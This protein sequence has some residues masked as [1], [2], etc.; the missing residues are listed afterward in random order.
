LH[1]FEERYK[2]MVGSALRDGS[3]FGIVLAKDEGIVNTG[4]TVRVEKVLQQYPDGRLDILTMGQRRFE[5]HR[6]N[7]ERDYLQGEVTYF[8]D[9]D[10]AT[11]PPELRELAVTNYHA[12][13]ELASARSHSEP[14]FADPQLSFQI[15]Q[16][17]PDLDFLSALLRQRSEVARLKELNHFLGAYVPRQ[18][19]VERMKDLAP[20][21]GFGHKP[22]GL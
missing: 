6:L 7:Q 13:S 10:L 21:N 20:R 17:V 5:I 22:A 15:A 12:L 14:D 16:A 8:D 11:A 4:C 1:I 19:S 18:R 3:E 2:D 9:E